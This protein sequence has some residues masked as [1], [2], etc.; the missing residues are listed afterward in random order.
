MQFYDP[1][2]EAW[3]TSSKK[4]QG[5]HLGSHGWRIVSS[6]PIQGS[7]WCA[8]RVKFMNPKMQEVSGCTVLAPGADLLKED[9]MP[10]NAF[11]DDASDG[12]SLKDS[13]NGIWYI[14][15]KCEKEQSV[16]TVELLQVTK[17]TSALHAKIQQLHAG[18]WLDVGAYI[19]V[20]VN[21]SKVIFEAATCNKNV[22]DAEHLFKS[23]SN[24]PAQCMFATCSQTECCDAKETCQSSNCVTAGWALIKGAKGTRCS[25]TCKESFCCE[26]K[27]VCLE[28]VC[29]PKLEVLKTS[30]PSLCKS[31]TCEVQE[32]C[33]A[34]VCKPGLC[35]QAA[36]TLKKKEALPKRCKSQTCTVSECCVLAESATGSAQ[37]EQ[38][39][40]S[41]DTMHFRKD[42]FGKTCKAS[43]CQPDECCEKALPKAAGK[44]KAEVTPAAGPMPAP[45]PVPK[46]A[47][48]A[49]AA[50]QPEVLTPV[51]KWDDSLFRIP[52]GLGEIG[53]ASLP[54]GLVILGAL[55]VFMVT[56]RARLGHAWLPS[57][58][59]EFERFVDAVSDSELA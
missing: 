21:A 35:Q 39:V 33:E 23:D 15:I 19:D 5:P 31:T 11:N 12:C 45:E 10:N 51:N 40:C 4:D 16:H 24:L 17:K 26:K 20:P 55:G 49:A 52:R 32:C 50:P 47:K 53:L 1:Q 38:D 8:R 6:A 59:S 3:L 22:C 28:N 29:S 42:A 9:F 58:A 2:V 30:I 44:A 14:G 37:C 43:V 41:A 27:G 46:A 34:P 25:G 56:V 18:S 57:G 7:E 54:A 36:A 48:A 13:Q